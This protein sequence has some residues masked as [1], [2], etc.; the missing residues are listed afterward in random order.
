MSRKNR[1]WQ[2]P[3]PIPDEP[4]LPLAEPEPPEPPVF[5]L[6]EPI[7]VP[8]EPSPESFPPKEE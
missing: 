8:R 5:P 7:T 6:P 3:P 1:K 4:V 2:A